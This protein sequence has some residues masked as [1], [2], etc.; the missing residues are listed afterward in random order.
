[1]KSLKIIAP[2]AIAAGA[3]AAVVLS[4]KPG[5]KGGAKGSA[6]AAKGGKPTMKNAKT[7]VYS[8]LS[9]Y[10]DPV[11]VDVKMDYDSEKFS[12]AVIEEDFVAYTSDSHVAAAYCPDFRMQIEYAGYYGGE[13]FAAYS[14]V[15]KEKYPGFAE[16]KYGENVGFKYV[17]G[18]SLCFCFPIP[19]DEFSYILVTVIREKD[20]KT[21]FEDMPKHPDLELMLSSIK[22]E[23][24]AN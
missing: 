23:T 22:F 1:M 10:R 7:G 19:N 4:K 20:C 2:I 13:D 9:G 6:K 8:F 3:A 16:A 5:E 18:D 17:D 14:Q 15:V 12:F 24:K 21:E 11:T